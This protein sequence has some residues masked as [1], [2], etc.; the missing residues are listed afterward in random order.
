MSGP[1]LATCVPSLAGGGLSNP[2]RRSRIRQ[3]ADRRMAPARERAV[4]GGNGSNP[5]RRGARGDCLWSATA[6]LGIF[7]AGSVGEDSLEHACG[8]TDLD[9]I[10]VGSCR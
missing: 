5:A 3:L 6:R 10:A 8:L 4:G 9:Q 2:A 7:L 1:A